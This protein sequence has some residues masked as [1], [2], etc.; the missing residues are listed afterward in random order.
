MTLEVLPNLDSESKLASPPPVPLLPCPPVLPGSPFLYRRGDARI[1]I[2]PI[3]RARKNL[4]HCTIDLVSLPFP[5][6]SSPFLGMRH[7]TPVIPIPHSFCL[8]F[9]LLVN[10]SLEA[11]WPG[12][13]L[14][15]PWGMIDRYIRG[16]RMGR[17]CHWECI[18]FANTG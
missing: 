5:G 18:H 7:H 4:Q 9:F 6:E 17:P 10:L 14:C 12:I 16:N 2:G 1:A 11:L 8:S 15:R 13:V 3:V